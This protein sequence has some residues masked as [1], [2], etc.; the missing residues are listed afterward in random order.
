[1]AAKQA[2]QQARPTLEVH[3]DAPESGPRK[4]VGQ[5][6]AH[7]RGF[8]IFLDS[9]PDR[10]GRMLM[11]RREASR[12]KKEGRPMRRLTD[13]DF[14]LG[15]HDLTRSGALRFRRGPEEP[16]IDDHEPPAP[17]V[18]SSPRAMPTRTT[19]RDTNAKAL[20]GSWPPRASRKQGSA[21]TASQVI[22]APVT[23]ANC[24][25]AQA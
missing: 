2:G 22:K 13:L 3:L 4:Q 7:T 17:P 5:H 25:R 16:S 6:A 1:M 14:M 12:A 24:S 20:D 23:A 10:W 18:T 15:V 9:A 8:G 19:P 11:E 21:T